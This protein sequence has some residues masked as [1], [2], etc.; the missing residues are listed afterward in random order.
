MK[1]GVLLSVAL[2]LTG[3]ETSGEARP[4]VSVKSLPEYA[5][6]Q[7][8]LGRQTFIYSKAEGSPLELGIIASSG[9]GGTRYTLYN[10]ITK[11]ESRAFA[12]GYISTSEQED[13][14]LIAGAIIR[15]R[16][17]QSPF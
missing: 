9:C 10:A 8:C 15:V 7:R 16:Q 4:K 6:H 2:L 12:Q 14:K 3:C 13:P 17:G 11:I 1:S 5:E